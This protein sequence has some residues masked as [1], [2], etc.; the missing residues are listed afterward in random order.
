MI[1][2]QCDGPGFCHVYKREMTQA[3]WDICH[4]A[5][6]WLK[7]R[8]AQDWIKQ[9]GATCAYDA[10]PLLDATGT[11]VVKRTCGCNGQPPVLAL[12]NCTNPQ[13]IASRTPGED[14]CIY[15]CSYFVARVAD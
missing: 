13:M 9:A 8:F 14:G 1:P 5:V 7:A 4:G 6:D 12:K 15:R 10:G 11:P 2:C 3:D